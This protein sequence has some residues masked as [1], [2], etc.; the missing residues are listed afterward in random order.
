MEMLVL[1][2]AGDRVL[3]FP[4]AMGRFYDWED[5]G[6]SR[7]VS[8]R[9]EQGNYQFY[10]V[11]SVESESW[12]NP[13]PPWARARRHEQY[14]SYLLNEVVPF[15]EGHSPNSFLITA[16]TGLGG[17]HAVNFGLRHTDRVQRVLA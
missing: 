12:Y 8:D 4:P 13:G 1:G 14:D 3:A 17:Y 15:S 5:C 9:I 16:R 2:H 11:D 10:C 6:L 7:S